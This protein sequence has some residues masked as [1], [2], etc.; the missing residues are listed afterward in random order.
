[1][2]DFDVRAKSVGEIKT[3]TFADSKTCS[4]YSAAY[5]LTKSEEYKGSVEIQDETYDS[6]YIG[7]LLVEGKEHADN[8][9]SALYKAIE[10]GWLK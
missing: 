5:V 9:I 10:L 8:L 6:N 2:S 4:G 1:M 7:Y 3:I